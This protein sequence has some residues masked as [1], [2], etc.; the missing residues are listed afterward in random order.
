M[1]RINKFVLLKEIR[2]MMQS[3]YFLG[4]LNVE[5]FHPLETHEEPQQH[6]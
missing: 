3:L 6:K 1:F 4:C 5:V 2:R